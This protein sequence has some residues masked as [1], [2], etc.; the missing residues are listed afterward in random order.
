MF[1]TYSNANYDLAGRLL[2]TI[3]GR[4]FDDYMENEILAPLGMKDASFLLTD[5]VRTK[6][7]TGYGTDGVT[8]VP[9][10]HMLGRPSGP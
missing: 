8:A 10:D 3:T 6:L 2:E 9:D 1:Y 5:S 7:A 4:S